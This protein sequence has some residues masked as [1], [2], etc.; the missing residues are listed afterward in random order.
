MGVRLLGRIGFVVPNEMD[1]MADFEANER[2]GLL[3]RGSTAIDSDNPTSTTTL[4]D[5]LRRDSFLSENS[6]RRHSTASYLPPYHEDP[7]VTDEPSSALAIWTVVPVSL[8]G[9][10]IANFDGSMVIASSQQIASEFDSLSNAPWLVTAFILAQ[11]ASQPLYGK[12]SDIFGRR[13]NLSVSYVFFAGGCFLCGCGQQY[14][15]VLTGRAVSGIGGAGMTALVSIII[16]DMV[17][18]REIASWRS[19][20]NIAATVGRALGGP[21]GGWLCDVLGWRWAFYVQVPITLLGL[22]LIIWRL[23][24]KVA[25]AP[26]NSNGEEKQSFRQKIAR[27][28]MLGALMIA[29][30]ITGFLLILQFATQEDVSPIYLVVSTVIFLLS[31]TLSYVIESRWAREPI[32]PI[33][34]LVDRAAITSYMLGGLQVAAQFAVFYSTPLYFQI[35]AHAAMGESGLRLVPAVVGNAVAGLLSGYLISQTG[36]YKLLTIVTNTFGCLGYLAIAVRWRGN[37]NWW[38]T[39]YIFC[40][41]FAAGTNQSTTFVHLAA[42]LDPEAIA[43]AGTM[44]YLFQSLF[45]LIGIQLATTVLRTTLSARLDTRLDG[46]VD[47]KSDVIHSTLSSVRYV[48]KLPLAIRAIVVR[49]YVDSFTDTFGKSHYSFVL[50]R[51]DPK[52]STTRSRS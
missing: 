24:T 26:T 1:K 18:V 29:V 9:V 32:L 15:V 20:V 45:M 27:V 38:E 21:L 23:P 22:L 30:T 25:K 39:L 46:M 51:S 40:G 2:T 47:N 5:S 31:G 49:A 16:A 17:P 37:T 19:Y 41:G 3:R 7:P 35:S 11:C 43:I 6:L 10:F 36:R 8:L 48:L 34:L 28:D 52:T 50:Y 13:S 12:L 42:S 33:E 44:L 4:R 14:G